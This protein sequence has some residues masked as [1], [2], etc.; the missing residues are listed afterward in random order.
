LSSVDDTR[1]PL[2]QPRFL[3]V[4]KPGG[5]ERRI[6]VVDR[7]DDAVYRR[8]VA[9]VSRMLER[10][11][12]PEVAANRVTAEEPFRLRSWREERGAFEGRRRALAERSDVVVKTDVRECYP[13]IGPAV[14]ETAFVRLGGGREVGSL[15][16]MLE[17]FGDAGVLGLP[18]GPAASAVV[19]N[20][21]L[22]RV[23]EVV[24]H[25]RVPHLRWVDDVW[26]GCRDERHAAEV[27][28]RIREALDSIGLALNE[29]K[30]LVMD[31]GEALS[32]V[33]AGSAP[34]SGY[35]E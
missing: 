2:R 22:A 33:A 18:I 13:S 29:S 4:P 10:V 16:R 25:A 14:A 20:A 26:A 7:L 24:R 35:S 28:D 27:L 11:L 32:L 15:R 12:G 8:V 17:R 1:R 5:G 21:V 9:R 23:D 31:R 6:T 34:V 19:A 30:T 3:I